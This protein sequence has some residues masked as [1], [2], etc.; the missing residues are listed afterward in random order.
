MQ[1][2]SFNYILALD[3]SGAFEEGKG[4]TG[5][6]LTKANG[7]LMRA[8]K[9]DAV[10]YPCPE[11]YWNEHVDLIDEMYDKYGKDLLIVAEDY[12]LYPGKA[13][14]QSYSK[15]E[16]SRLIGIIQITCYNSHI[17]LEFQRAVEIKTRWQNTV[18]INEGLLKLGKYRTP[19]IKKDNDWVK[20]NKHILD[21][22]RHA[23]HYTRFKNYQT[24]T[25]KHTDIKFTNYDN[26]RE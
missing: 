4:C 25:K 24:T 14:A 26:Y 16:T 8:G 19:F 5:W 21:A 10:E 9:I 15:L 2:R 6:V 1:N 22:Y 23:M 17:P 11:E 12:I 20:I 18:L 13:D 3:P 7:D